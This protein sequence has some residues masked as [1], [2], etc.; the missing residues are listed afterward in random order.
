MYQFSLIHL[1]KNSGSFLVRGGRRIWQGKY[2][3]VLWLYMLLIGVE[4]I[5]LWNAQCNKYSKKILNPTTTKQVVRGILLGREIL[6]Y[7]I[8]D[9]A[10]YTLATIYKKQVVMISLVH[11]IYSK[12]RDQIERFDRRI[13]E[14]SYQLNLGS[15]R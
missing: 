13:L 15:Q 8:K 6:T 11:E 4:L 12:K 5:M 1:K 3:Q 10:I 9:Q 14:L 2:N 7:V